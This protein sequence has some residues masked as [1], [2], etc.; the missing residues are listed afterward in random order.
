MNNH[1]STLT[2]LLKEAIETGHQSGDLMYIGQAAINVVIFIPKMD[3]PALSEEV[4]KYLAV[5]KACKYEE[6][7]NAIESTCI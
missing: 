2:P 6:A 4:K 7:I 3:L 5:T 1:W